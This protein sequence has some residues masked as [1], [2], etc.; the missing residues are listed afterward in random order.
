MTTIKERTQKP[1]GVQHSICNA[2]LPDRGAG[3]EASKEL[4]SASGEAEK[5]ISRDE[6][7]A[8]LGRVEQA[9]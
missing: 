8:C 5:R 3:R 1:T 7:E 2:L 4:A 6:D 9:L